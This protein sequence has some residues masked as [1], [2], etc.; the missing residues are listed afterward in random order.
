MVRIFLVRTLRFVFRHPLISAVGVV[1]FIAAIVA[2][3]SAGGGSTT[4]ENRP[5]GKNTPTDQKPGHTGAGGQVT[6]APTKPPS[7]LSPK[8]K[9]SFYD[10]KFHFSGGVPTQSDVN[11][12]S[13]AAQQPSPDPQDYDPATKAAN[14]KAHLDMP[15]VQDLPLVEDGVEADLTDQTPDGGLVITVDYKGSKRHAEQIWERF[16]RKEKDPGTAY[17]VLYVGS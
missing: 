3:S 9:K 2:L 11:H 12:V 10:E 15:A 14:V 16:L 7:S 8:E 4:I 1:A 17:T 6:P 5:M 13:T